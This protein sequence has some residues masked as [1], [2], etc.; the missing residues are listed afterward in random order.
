MLRRLTIA[1]RLVLGFGVLLVLLVGAVML[2]LSRLASVE[3]I[4][5]RIVTQDWQKT[6]LA[7]NT[8]DL[9][10]AQ[11]RD[12]FLLFHIPDRDYPAVR[13]RIAERVDAI[14]GRLE[15]LDALL[16][17][18]EGKARLTEIRDLRRTYVESFQSVSRLLEAGQRELASQRMAG[19][20][21]QAL[22]ALIGSIDRLIGLQGRLLEQSGKEAAASYVS[23]RNQL[24]VFLAL[25]LILSV[26]LSVWIIRAVTR[27]LGGEPDAAKAAV[28]R[29]AQGDLTTGIEVRPGDDHSLLAAL[30]GMQRNLRTMI[31]DLTGNANGVAA[32]AEQ[33]AVASRQIATSSAQQSDAASSMASAVEQMTVSIGRVSDS[34]ADAR[35]VTIDAGEYSANGSAVIGR[36]V[37][38]MQVIADTVAAAAQTIQMVG[39]SSQK[40]S[41]IVQVIKEV[42][43]QTNLLALNAA[44]EAARAGEQGRGFAV[45][46]DEVRKLAERTAQATMDIGNMIENMQS[47]SGEAVR[48]MEQAVTYVEGGVQLASQAGDSM[49][50]ISSGARRAVAAVNEISDALQEQSAASNEIAANV[51]RI[52]QMSEENS[53]ATQQ[54]HATAQQL[55]ALAASTLG[56][57]R[58]FRI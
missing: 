35:H 55:Q 26:I 48:T 15:Q 16:Y 36:T 27:P 17:T 4:V 56:A 46:A 18:P 22:E 33:L 13:A 51:E 54:A 19:E 11:T 43:D 23:A 30:Q 31:G 57:V 41:T 20:T 12:T 5:S 58:V 53:A 34:A 52:A 38:E 42:A 6:V 47:R 3:Q 21:T 44:I 40:I 50:Q 8:I 24:V 14:T 39:D 29:I 2:G 28:E 9:M 45:V 32:A 7:N 37:T 25:A 10:N 49:G 1:T